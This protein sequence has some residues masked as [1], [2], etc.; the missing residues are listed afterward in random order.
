MR[1]ALARLALGLI[2]VLAAPACISKPA[3]TTQIYALDPAPIRVT[4]PAPG[5]RIVSVS[6]VEVAP[7]FASRSL[8]YRSGPHSFERDPYATLAA[9][10][11]ELLLAM[12]RAALANADDVRE[13]VE[14][15]GPVAPEILVEAYLSDLEGDFTVPDKPVA[16][17]GLEVVVLT[18][19]PAPDPILPVLRK[20]Y[21]RRVPLPE[22]TAAAV[23]NAWNQQL[24]SVIDEFIADMR[25]ALPPPPAPAVR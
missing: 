17:L 7:Q 11:R 16:A 5:A 3:V 4:T 8:T 25:A 24:T 20:S 9:S 10:P 18:V 1:P 14:P 6:R 21:G 13:V 23:A 2:W 22:R 12:L 15:G 19:P